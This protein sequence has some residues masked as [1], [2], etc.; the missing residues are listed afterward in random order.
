MVDNSVLFEFSF[1]CSDHPVEVVR[2]SHLSPRYFFGS[3]SSDP[4]TSRRALD[5]DDVGENVDR[6]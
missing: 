2:R 3:R 4:Q 1:S 5:F 6:K